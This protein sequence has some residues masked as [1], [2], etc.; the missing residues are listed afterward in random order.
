MGKKKD[1]EIPTLGEDIEKLK[2]EEEVQDTQEPK[3]FLFHFNLYCL[4]KHIKISLI[5]TSSKS[6]MN[7]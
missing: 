4:S 1:E 7:L 2:A 5:V 6:I 3:V